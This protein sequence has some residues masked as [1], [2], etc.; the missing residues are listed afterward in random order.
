[1]TG[2]LPLS[3][4]LSLSLSHTHTHTQFSFPSSNQLPLSTHSFRSLPGPRTYWGRNQV[5]CLQ[6]L[7]WS[8]MTAHLP[9]A[10]GSGLLLPARAAPQDPVT[11]S[12]I[13]RGMMDRESLYGL[14]EVP[15]AKDT[16]TPSLM[17]FAVSLIT[18]Q[19][20]LW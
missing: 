7:C 3:L 2:P 18:L 6:T 20:G 4:S 10:C 11:L 13:R 8:T 15:P 14:T 1:M 16:F 17:T 5:L 12:S 9:L 19:S